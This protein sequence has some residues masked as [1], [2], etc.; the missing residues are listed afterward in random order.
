MAELDL[1]P[2]DLK[3]VQ[4]AKATSK[5][6]GYP[7][8]ALELPNGEIVTGK[9]KKVISASGAVV[10]NALRTLAG[11]G[12]DFDVIKDEIL[13]PIIDLRTRYLNSTSSVLTL[14]DVLVALAISSAKNPKA[15]KAIACLSQLQGCEAHSTYIL[16][17]AEEGTFKKL[18]VNITCQPQFLNNHL[19]ND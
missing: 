5:S 15:K 11:L 19:F 8:V 14:D 18:L 12:D 7:C 16:S 2:K 17:P 1:S 3:V 4:T 6:S 10:L 9:T 13:M